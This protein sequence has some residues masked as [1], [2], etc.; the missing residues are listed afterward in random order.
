[1]FYFFYNKKCVK[2]ARQKFHQDIFVGVILQSFF[3]KCIKL[4]QFFL[5]KEKYIYNKNG[6]VNFLTQNN[7]SGIFSLCYHFK[8]HF[9][10]KNKNINIFFIKKKTCNY[11]CG[12]V[13]FLTKCYFYNTCAQTTR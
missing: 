13:N 8:T 2:I 6:Y 5:I 12:C 1:M 9:Q 11:I 10:K 7:H 4:L 3:F